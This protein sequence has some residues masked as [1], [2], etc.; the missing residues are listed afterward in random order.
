[1]L[2]EYKC[3]LCGRLVKLNTVSVC[4]WCEEKICKLG[5]KNQNCARSKDLICTKFATKLAP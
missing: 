4:A 3:C 1:M 2:S 5:H